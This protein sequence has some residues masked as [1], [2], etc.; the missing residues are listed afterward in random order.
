MNGNDQERRLD[1]IR[2]FLVTTVAKVHLFCSVGYRHKDQ[3]LDKVVGFR[4]LDPARSAYTTDQ[5]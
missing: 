5:Y 3:D 2:P 1:F 4:L